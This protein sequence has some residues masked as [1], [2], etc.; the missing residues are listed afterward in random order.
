MDLT[1]CYNVAMQVA[2]VFFGFILFAM[3]WGGAVISKATVL[4][5]AGNIRSSNFTGSK[6]Q[7]PAQSILEC[8]GG[9][10]VKV[11]V[12]SPQ[13]TANTTVKVQQ[14]FTDYGSFFE[15]ATT[16]LDQVLSSSTLPPSSS[17]IP[18]LQG[19]KCLVLPT[20]WDRAITHQKTCLPPP[21]SPSITY[22]AEMCDTVAM[23]WVWC[24]CLI[25]VTPYVF[26]FLRCLWIVLFRTKKWPS[27]QVILFVSILLFAIIYLCT[28][29]AQIARSFS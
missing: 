20:D 16:G 24:L 5:A 6:H 23:Q 10:D 15:M 2:K 13:S 4:F 27:V 21:Q 28:Q 29:R 11:R 8:V 22:H 1:A 25:M 14:D 17:T 9:T 3:V 26:A 7:G 18:P 19:T 12:H